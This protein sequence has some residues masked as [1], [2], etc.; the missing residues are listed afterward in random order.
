[1]SPAMRNFVSV[2]ALSSFCIVRIGLA[3]AQVVALRMGSKLR[4]SSGARQR[5]VAAPCLSSIDNAESLPTKRLMF[6]FFPVCFSHKPEERMKCRGKKENMPG[7]PWKGEK[8]FV[9]MQSQVLN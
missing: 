5:H 1:M 9:M 8:H 2:K 3:G 6:S 7:W 4:P